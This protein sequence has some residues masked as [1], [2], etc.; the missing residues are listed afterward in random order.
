MKVI[1]TETREKTQGND[2]ANK[3]G[4]NF[5]NFTIIKTKIV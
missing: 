2:Q 5:T 1:D 4:Q 3:L